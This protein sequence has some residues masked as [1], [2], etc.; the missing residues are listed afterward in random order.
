M[1]KPD[2]INIPRGFLFSTVEAAIKKPGRK[3]LALIFSEK[4]AA[5]AGMFTKN[6]VKA[7]PVLLDMRLVKSGK[8][9]A[10]VVNSGNANAC[11][12]KQGMSDAL[13]I[14]ELTASGLK[15]KTNSVFVCST[16]V[17]GNPMP[18]ERIR[19]KLAELASNIGKSSINDVAAAMMTTDTFP[20]IVSRRI[21]IAGKAVTIAGIC[22]GAGMIRPDMATMLC[23][24]MTD[25]CIDKS[26]LG[27]AL[28]EAV[29]NSFN[30][31]TVDGDMSTNDTVLIMANAMAGNEEIK[32]DTRAFKV[33]CAALSALCYELARMIIQ[34]GEGATK[35]VEIEVRNAATDKDAEKAA[36]T[37]ANSPLVKTA[38]YGNDANWGRI[39]AAVG[40]SGAN[41]KEE[42]TDIFIN[43]LK[44]AARGLSTGKDKE[45]NDRLKA[46]EVSIVID[47]NLGRGKAKVLTCDLTEDYI[48]INA[49]YRT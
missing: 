23:F 36:F 27:S 13:E 19:P 26:F 29:K 3:D 21:R 18:M 7:A 12:G 4:D 43:G 17:I 11:T 35:L 8:G 16:G 47:L 22:K 41:I 28:K 30:R 14:A 38:I 15:I 5:M 45:A 10:I 25:A 46:K 9:R 32:K 48:K 1:S 31:I 49:E 20:K 24:L 2:N 6:K 34:D 42:T 40:Y 44:V 39:M 33:F 37:A